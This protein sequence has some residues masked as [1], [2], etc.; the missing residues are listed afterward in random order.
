[1]KILT[2]YV[3]HYICIINVVQS[4][5]NHNFENNNKIF[6]LKTHS[7]Y[8]DLSQVMSP[9]RWFLL[10]NNK[11]SKE[12]SIVCKSKLCLFWVRS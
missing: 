10:L 6:R 12:I 2:Y 11:E 8:S 1:M 4:K 3:S 5:I 7:L 9:K